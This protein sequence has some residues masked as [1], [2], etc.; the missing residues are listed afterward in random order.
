MKA[1]SFKA[2]SDI[3]RCWYASSGNPSYSHTCLATCQTSLNCLLSWL[4]LQ[5]ILG[6]AE[7]HMSQGLMRSAAALYLAG[8]LKQRPT[9][10]NAEEQY[11][12]QRFFVF[13]QIAA[14]APLSFDD[15]SSAM[16]LEGVSPVLKPMFQIALSNI[17][18]ER[19]Y[20]SKSMF[21]TR[22]QQC[23][24]SSPNRLQFACWFS[25]PSV[26]EARKRSQKLYCADCSA[27]DL[28]RIAALNFSEVRGHAAT[29]LKS[30][31]A[32]P[33]AAVRP[34]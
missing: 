2:V 10:F 8:S 13:T 25:L 17:L 26:Y 20:K 31:D 5:G 34:C 22:L 4:F 32:W 18:S 19:S 16:N 1:D 23:R 7:K 27:L 14:P 28:M 6:A 21:S 15:Y 29:V 3:V 30:K 11:F 9:P 12:E 33:P 24:L